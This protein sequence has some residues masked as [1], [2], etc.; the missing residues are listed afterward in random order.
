MMRNLKLRQY[1]Y[2]IKEWYDTVG[3]IIKI[4]RS[5]VYN[6]IRKK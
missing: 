6:L 5:K 3:K 1:K 2:F 4:D